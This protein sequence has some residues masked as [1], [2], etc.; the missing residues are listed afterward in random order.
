MT[1]KA[2]TEKEQRIILAALL[3]LDSRWKRGTA[4]S[5]FSDKTM[6]LLRGSNRMSVH[7]S[8]V[9]SLYKKLKACES[10]YTQKLR[11]TNGNVT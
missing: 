8:E 2:L 6:E 10:L 9:L 5:G 1:E 4:N 3:E 11:A 7:E